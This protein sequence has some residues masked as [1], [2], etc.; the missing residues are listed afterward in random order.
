[1]DTSENSHDLYGNVVL[2]HR[3]VP[4]LLIGA[5]LA[6]Y[7]LYLYAQ[8]ICE[9]IQSICTLLGTGSLAFR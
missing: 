1:L 6:C 9:V 5:S 4:L 7:M 3:S 2:F 8:Y